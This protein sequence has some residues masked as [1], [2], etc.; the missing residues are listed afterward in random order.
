[1]FKNV[2]QISFHRR[3]SCNF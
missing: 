2:T 1:M 3:F